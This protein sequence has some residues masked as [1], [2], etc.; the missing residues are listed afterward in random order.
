MTNHE[1]FQ[2]T[3][4]IKKKNGDFKGLCLYLRRLLSKMPDEYYLLAELSAACYQLEKYDA[5]LTY[6]HEAY[7]LASKDYWVRYI[8]GCAL[9]AKDKLDDAA[10]MFDSIMACDVNYLANY[11]HGEGKRFAESLL[12]DSQ[13]MKA[14]INQQKGYYLEARDLFLRHKKQ[15]KRGLYSDFTIRQVNTHLKY[16]NKVIDNKEAN[17][18]NDR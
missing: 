15:R 4:D 12:N 16:L 1:T 10:E 11:E 13:Y 2:R 14:V 9:L 6:A 8:Y 18:E 3:I 5:S 7:Q 17:D